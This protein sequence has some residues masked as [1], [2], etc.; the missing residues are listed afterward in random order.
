MERADV[1]DLWK[2]AE[3]RNDTTVPRQ[4]AKFDE[5][6]W[7]SGTAIYD[8]KGGVVTHYGLGQTYLALLVCPDDDSV[9]NDKGNLSYVVNGGPTVVWQHPLNNS[10]APAWL[11]LSQGTTTVPPNYNQIPDDQRAAQNL[12]LMYPGSVKGNTIWDVK[13]SLSQISDGSSSTVMITENL[14][15]GYAASTNP[16]TPVWY[17]AQHLGQPQLPGTAE[18]SWANPD[19]FF[20]AVHLSDDFCDPAGN[21]MT[22]GNPIQVPFGSTS[23]TV[24]RASFSKCNSKDARDNTKTDPECI[25]GNFAAD[26]GWSYPSSYHPGGINVVMCDGSAR[27]VANEIDGEI[28][29]KLVSPGGTRRMK[30]TYAVFQ[31]P[32]DENQ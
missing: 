7:S 8:K 10:T 4:L 32:L 25:N 16:L 21:C 1:A 6:D 30:E 23:I 3:L 2:S 12:G 24:T 5:G 17:D 31:T 20:S 27:F 13:R 9:Q 22:S 19:P 14:R 29:A 15:A 11:A 18:G 28:W 26:E